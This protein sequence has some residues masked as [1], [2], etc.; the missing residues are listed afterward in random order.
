MSA[1]YEKTGHMP[2]LSMQARRDRDK[3]QS[4]RR[5][6]PAEADLAGIN[7]RADGLSEH[8]HVIFLSIVGEEL[9]ASFDEAIISYFIQHVRFNVVKTT[10][11]RSLYKFLTDTPNFMLLLSYAA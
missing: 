7:D 9:F 8:V 2:G 11:K 4:E 6:H 3:R 5:R 1:A 10:L